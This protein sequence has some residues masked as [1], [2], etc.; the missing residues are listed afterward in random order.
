MELFHRIADPACARVRKAIVELGLESKVSFRNVDTG[1]EAKIE[2][3]SL[4]GRPDVPVLKTAQ[5]L[6]MGEASV[7]KYLRALTAV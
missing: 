6:I 2:F 3:A 1:T 5:G 7:L 4:V